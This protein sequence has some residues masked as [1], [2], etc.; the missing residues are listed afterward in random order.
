MAIIKPQTASRS[1]RAFQLA[2][3]AAGIVA[4]AV[5]VY[6]ALALVKEQSDQTKA[7]RT[8]AESA[9]FDAR[10]QLSKNPR[11]LSA[12][13][14]LAKVYIGIGQYD[15]ALS[16]L[17]IALGLDKNN[18]EAQYLTGLAYFEMGDNNKALDSLIKAS[19]VKGAFAEQ[20]TLVW[21]QMGDTYVKMGRYRDA[22]Q[23]Y[24]TALSYKPE[25]AD[26]VFKLAQTFEKVGDTQAALKAYKGVLSFVP[27]DKQA[28]DAVKRL[29]TT[30]KR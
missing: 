25:A 15:T 19:K 18:E 6:L 1:L 4:V 20:L 23:A 12:R 29:Q 30:E 17:K 21:Q 16:T 26:V 13:L 2:T 22:V 8:A 27:T 9:L 7:P 11:D 5:V 24:N 28:Q 10:A 3:F 14:N